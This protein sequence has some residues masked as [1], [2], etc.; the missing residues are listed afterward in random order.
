MLFHKS[1]LLQNNLKFKFKFKVEQINK[2]FEAALGEVFIKKCSIVKLIM[3][4]CFIHDYS[5]S[6]I[7]QIQSLLQDPVSYGIL[8]E[9]QTIQEVQLVWKNNPYF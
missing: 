8:A 4:V 9:N 7:C 1:P 2:D 3:E 6:N 5:N